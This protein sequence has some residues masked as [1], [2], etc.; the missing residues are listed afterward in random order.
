MFS[1][2]ILGVLSLAIILSFVISDAQKSQECDQQKMD[3][4]TRW[5]FFF[6]DPKRKIPETEADRFKFCSEKIQK[7]LYVKNY[8]KRCLKAFP[9]QVTTLLMYGVIRKNKYYCSFKRGKKDIVAMAKCLNSI[10]SN[11]NKCMSKLID[12]AMA[13]IPL[14]D[15][16]R[17][18]ASIC[19]NYY[20]FEEC[21]SHEASESPSPHCTHDSVILIEQLLEG[22]TGQMLGHICTQFR[23]DT[24]QCSKLVPLPLSKPLNSTVRYKSILPPFIEIL[25]SIPA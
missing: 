9:F 5:L 21:V 20:K 23:R 15:N 11:G 7:E 1:T 24:D 18:I 4:T 6:G 17:K 22:Y 13:T 16:N 2:K 14:K 19:C 8:A 10:K 3:E 25:D 12:E